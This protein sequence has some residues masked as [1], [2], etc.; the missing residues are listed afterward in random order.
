MQDQRAEDRQPIC[1][2]TRGGLGSGPTDQPWSLDGRQEG[3]CPR[4][5]DPVTGSLTGSNLAETPSLCSIRNGC[6]SR[7]VWPWRRHELRCRCQN[8]RQE[9]CEWASGCRPERVRRCRWEFLP[10][11]WT[12]GA[13]QAMSAR[14]EASLTA[15]V[16]PELIK[17]QQLGLKALNCCW[18][19]V[20]AAT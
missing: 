1:L 6:W 14:P 18:E 12:A 4:S 2:R 8:P 10:F 5:R 3:S 20:D 9:R 13:G 19:L 7:L 17:K 16:H 15:Y 11:L